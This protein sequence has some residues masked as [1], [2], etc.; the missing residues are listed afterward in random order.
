MRTFGFKVV[1][2]LTPEVEQITEYAIGIGAPLEVGLFFAE[3]KARDFLRECLSPAPSPVSVHLDHRRLALLG[4]ARDLTLLREQLASA[5]ELGAGLVVIHLGRY[6]MTARRSLRP[7]LWER[8]TA[9]LA[10][11][12]SV[13][14]DC[15]IRIHIENTFHPLPFYRELY[16]ALAAARG[17]PPDICFDIGHAKVWSSEP[18][19]DWLA[20]LR[21][22]LAR[23]AR[24]HCHLHANQ[25]LIDEHRAFTAETA[26][27]RDLAD[28]FAPGL[29]WV[30]TLAM[31]S[32]S[33][34][35]AIKILEVPPAEAIATHA[36]ILTA[37]AETEGA[38]T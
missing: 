13:A 22:Q 18:L 28:D 1:D 37:L 11:A 29:T 27:E 31:L 19:S 17:C 4:I 8:L 23:G 34:P 36:S 21:G 16:T 15:G 33:L 6:P 2:R 32:K 24:M 10:V 25:G 20:L 35:E 3:P 26:A 5:A 14:A 12:E 9:D 7:S 38:S 30:E